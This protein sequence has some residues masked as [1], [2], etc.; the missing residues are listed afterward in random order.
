MTQKDIQNLL[1][2]K[3]EEK[4]GYGTVPAGRAPFRKM[5][6]SSFHLLTSS[7]FLSTYYVPGFLPGTL[8]IAVNNTDQVPDLSRKTCVRTPQHHPP[9]RQSAPPTSVAQSG[10]APSRQP[11]SQPASPPENFLFW[12]SNVP[13]SC[14]LSALPGPYATAWTALLTSSSQ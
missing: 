7:I 6:I 4:A 9:A 14:S 10:H 11:A 1:F 8:H 2:T 12:S 5:P 13:S 3:G